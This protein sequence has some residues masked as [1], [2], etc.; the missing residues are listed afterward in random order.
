MTY[1]N[2]DS[3]CPL[4]GQSNRC[5]VKASSGCWCMNTEIPEALLA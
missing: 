2:D 5:D 4:C 1:K 3:I